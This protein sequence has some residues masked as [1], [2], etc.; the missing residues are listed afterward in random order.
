MNETGTL[1]ALDS[2]SMRYGDTI[3]LDAA[4]FK[5]AQGEVVALLGPNGAGKSTAFG[6]LTG[7]RRPH[8]G[9]AT[10]FGTDPRNPVSRSRVG[11]TP[12]ES[13][14]P[15]A[16][17]VTELLDFASAHFP[18]AASRDVLLEAFGL[19]ELAHKM[20]NTLSGGQQRRVALALAFSPSPELVFLDEPTTGIDA[21]RRRSIWQYISEFKASGGSILLTTH[22]FEEAEAIADRIVVIDH[23][24]VLHDGNLAE[25][26]RRV[27]Y[28]IIR[29]RSPDVVDLT[30]ARRISQT[31]QMLSF[32]SANSDATLKEIF[33]VGIQFSDLEVIPATLEEAITQILEE[34]R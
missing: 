9:S 32:A 6:V 2:V 11:V 33:Q 21:A 22:Q 16:V 12:Q 30:T 13:S 15:H 10:L 4:S 14:F 1:A 8:S 29:F 24:R 3:A 26:K 5:V 19:Q 23:G 18:S 17:K 28:R 7:L 20:A 25:V 27:A 34:A 31:G